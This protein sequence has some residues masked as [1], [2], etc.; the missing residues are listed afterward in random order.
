M[1]EIR[2]EGNRRT[3]VSKKWMGI[4]EEEIKACGVD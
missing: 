4:T 1:D 2:V 3:C